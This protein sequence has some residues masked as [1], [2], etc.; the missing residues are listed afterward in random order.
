VAST[1]PP[2]GIGWLETPEGREWLDSDDGQAW[3]R[4]DAGWRW[5]NSSP[6]EAWQESMADRRFDEHL[7]GRHTADLPEWAMTPETA[8]RVGDRVRLTRSGRTATGVTFTAG[9]LGIVVETRLAPIGCVFVT[10]RMLDGRKML[11]TMASSFEP[12]A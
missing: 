8:P 5:L 10:I 4:T 12:A 7:S 2:H 11:T 9:E 6:G 1:D 3:I